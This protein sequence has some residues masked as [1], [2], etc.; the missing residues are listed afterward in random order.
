MT[1]TVLPASDAPR[2]AMS[3]GQIMAVI[4]G[5]MIGL[6][7]AALD[8][9]IV[10]TA[11]PTM[12]GELGGLEQLSWVVTAYL[13][14]STVT[15]PLYGKIS[16]L[17]GRKIV[18]QAA[19]ILFLA[20]SIL[21]GLSQNMG[22]LIAF[23]GLQGLG[24][25]GLFVMA[26]TIIGDI[27]SPRERGRYQ[28]YFGA[29]FALS[30]VAGPLAGGWLVDN[31]DWRWVFYVNV[32]IGLVALFVTASALNLPFVRR[33]HPIDYWGAGTLV[34]SV[35]ALLLAMVW[36][37]NEYEWGSPLIIGLLVIG[38]LVALLF[39]WWERRAQEPIL[40]PRLFRNRTFAL[41]SASGFIIG[42][43]MFGGIVFLPLFL[44]VVVGASA[45]NSGLLLIPMMVGII[46]SS[47]IGGRLI[48]HSGRY[49]IFPVIGS[50]LAT[51]AFFLLSTMGV[52]TVLF[53]A[54][55]YMFI[56]GVG[57]GM[58]MPVLVLAVQNAV[59]HSDLGVATSSN[60]FFRS[61]GGAFG[62]ALLGAVFTSQ[63]T[64]ALAGLVPEGGSG[65]LTSS[66][67]A[68]AALPEAVRTQ[69]VEA[70][71]SS[72]GTVFLVALPFTVLALVLALMTPELP[73]RET[74]HLGAVEA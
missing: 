30:S 17:Y 19:I 12:V 3:H 37:G 72:I 36:G 53:T 58:I 55:V 28:G 33:D 73:L 39:L 4:W 20:G 52:G 22:Q 44:Q 63:L 27:L 2:V 74:A 43:A 66:P 51:L 14:A 13:L 24:A 16:D 6:F 68:I 48:T 32:P 67:A 70:F 60:N 31:V 38:V 1:D 21:C 8:Q 42:L 62:T 46:G 40:P 47:V 10:A 61:L 65:Q 71:A 23:R 64:K 41:T 57:V 56:L 7:L 35:S 69:V 50:A 18:F 29:V 26:M 5:L 9:T 25:G 34:V 59:D 45:T 54:S 15:A 11:L 49:K